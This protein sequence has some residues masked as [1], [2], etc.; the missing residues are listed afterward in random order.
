MASSDAL[1]RSDVLK[2][3]VAFVSGGGSGI[4]AAIARQL[5]RMGARLAIG[6][7]KPD[8]IAR[9]AA[10]LSE[11]LGQPVLGITCDI[12]DRESVGA[13]VAET[14]EKLGRLDILVNTGGG[15]FMS[16]AEAIRPRGWDAVVATNLTGTWNLTRAAADAWLLQH[17]G[18]VINITMLTLRGFPGMAHSVS[19]RAGVEAMSRTLAVEW[20]PR[21]IT[22]NCVQ[23]GIIATPGVRQY[24]FWQEVVKH[25][26]RATPAKRLG[27][28]EE[29]AG[30][31]GFLASPSASFVTGQVMAVDGGRSLWGDGWPLSDPEPFPE[32][33]IRDEP[34]EEPP[35]DG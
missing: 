31:V 5:G 3:Q 26:A 19:A 27:T 21:G 23:P 9:A 11:E 16:P 25:A 2:G 24:P 34:W 33:V 35:S 13:A 7:R 8:R 4:G 30:L 6:S 10:G 12:R 1:F 32:V 18:R 20:A 29:V 14:I 28:A 22:V 17:G 15:Q